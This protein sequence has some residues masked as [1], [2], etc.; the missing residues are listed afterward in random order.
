MTALHD[1]NAR[2]LD[3]E[4]VSDAEIRAALDLDDNV[5]V[6]E[7]RATAEA[8][9]HRLEAERAAAAAI[10]GALDAFAADAD[11]LVDRMEAAGAVFDAAVAEMVAASADL[12][13]V[14]RTHRDILHRLGWDVTHPDEITVR[15]NQRV[16]VMREQLGH[17]KLKLGDGREVR[18][19]DANAYVRW[20]RNEQELRHGR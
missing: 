2:L 19:P 20:A 13:T 10:D 4:Q 1:V 6:A 16:V 17:M 18:L 7:I 14:L 3:G 9:R 5:R 15:T 12:D 8:K 11:R